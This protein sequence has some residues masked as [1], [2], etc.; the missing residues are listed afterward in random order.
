ME[1]VAKALSEDERKALATYYSKLPIPAAAA[2]GAAAPPD[3][4]LGKTLATRGRWEKQVP[5]CV[6]CHG[7]H[8][9]GVGEHFPPLAGQSAT[10]IANQLHDWKNGKRAN[11]PLQL[12]QHVVSALS[13]KDIQAVS[14]WFAAQ[15]AEVEGGNP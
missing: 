6:Q 14:E 8:G 1:P 12:M 11:D 10:Y 5:G 7:P 3:D 13:D 9:V 2:K 4:A 15:P